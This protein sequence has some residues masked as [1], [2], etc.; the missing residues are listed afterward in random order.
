MV[1]HGMQRVEEAM[2]QKVRIPGKARRKRSLT[3]LRMPRSIFVQQKFGGERMGQIAE[4]RRQKYAFLAALTLVAALSASSLFAAGHAFAAARHSQAP[5]AKSEKPFQLTST[6]FEPD[7]AIPVK[8]ACIGANGSPALAWTDP[9]AGTQSFALIVDDPDASSATP[10]VHWLI[11][12]IP[13]S[14]R[15]L[16]ENTPKKPTLPDGSRQGKNT[17]GKVGYSGPCPDPGKLHHYFFKLYAL[18]YI[19]DLKAKGKVVDVEAAIKDHVLAKSELI[20]RYQRE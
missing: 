18:D 11:Y 8:Y 14:Q 16:A 9:P 15:S 13:S 3:P 10:A 1:H 20:G 12:A 7:S 5:Q 2:H 6:A 19:P 17:A 4:I